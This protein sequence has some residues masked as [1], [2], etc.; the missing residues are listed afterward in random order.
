MS[1]NTSGASLYDLGG[2][3]Q[4]NSIGT[5]N[6]IIKKSELKNQEQRQQDMA[7]Q[8]KLKQMESESAKEQIAMEQDFESKENDKRNRTNI[9]I[10]EIKASGFGSTSDMDGNGQNDFLD[11]MDK[12]KKTDAYVDTVGIQDRKASSDAKFKGEELNVKR[13]EMAL[14]RELK[15]KDL[16]IAKENKNS[17]DSKKK[18]V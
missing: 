3:I 6:S 7:H 14:K 17:F 10:S 11:A 12:I 13:E 9:L 1:N 18:E 16:Q 2:V 5:L 8:E 15:E 4:A